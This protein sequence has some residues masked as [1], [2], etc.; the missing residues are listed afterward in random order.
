MVPPH[1]FSQTWMTIASFERSFR[2]DLSAAQPTPVKVLS[3]V[4]YCTIMHGSSARRLSPSPLTRRSSFT[5]LVLLMLSKYSLLSSLR[6]SL[7]TLLIR[8]ARSPISHG[9]PPSDVMQATP[10]QVRWHEGTSGL[11][12]NTTPTQLM[13]PSPT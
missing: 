7:Q 8:L 6:R 12:W 11:L 4:K 5:L 10:F 13:G 3:P 2:V 1:F 9:A